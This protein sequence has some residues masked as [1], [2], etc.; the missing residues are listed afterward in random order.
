MFSSTIVATSASRDW[1][2]HETGK[3]CLRIRT[4]E[5]YTSGVVDIATNASGTLIE[6]M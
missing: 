6:S 3:I 4:L 1:I 2:S 5:K